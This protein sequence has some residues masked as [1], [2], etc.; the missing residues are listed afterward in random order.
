MP[1]ERTHDRLFSPMAIGATYNALCDLGHDALPRPCVNDHETDVCDF[2]RRVQ[3][4]EVQASDIALTA[5]DARVLQQVP[6]ETVL[7]LL[8][9]ALL[10]SSRVY[11]VSSP[12]RDI[13]RATAVAAARL[14]TIGAL[15]SLVEGRYRPDHLTGAALLCCLRIHSVPPGGTDPPSAD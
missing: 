12:V 9:R 11:H 7:Q 5:V 6:R 10:A 8:T 1:P 2:G 13:P 3:V 14:Q 15:T 4:V